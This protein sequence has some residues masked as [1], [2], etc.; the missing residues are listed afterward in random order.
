MRIKTGLFS[1]KNLPLAKN[2]NLKGNFLRGIIFP[3]VIFYGSS[4]PQWGSGRNNVAIMTPGKNSRRVAS[5]RPRMPIANS[6]L[7]I[8]KIER[9]KISQPTQQSIH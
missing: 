5:R 9:G 2:L 4:S 8:E 3:M 1:P 6:Y 7:K